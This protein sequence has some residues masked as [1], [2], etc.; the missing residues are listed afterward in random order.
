MQKHTRLNWIDYARGIAIILVVYRHLFE[1]LKRT[2]AL[3]AAGVNVESYLSLEHANIFFFSFRMPLFFIVSGVFVGASLAKRGFASLTENKARTILYPY[4]LW[5]II[6][7]G[8]QILF[9]A[10]INSKK[11]VYDFLYLLYSPREVEQFWYLYALFNTIIIFAFLKQNA[12]FKSI[13]QIILGFI[14]FMASALCS[15]YNIDL[16]FVSDIL[17]YYIFLALGDELSHL[18]IMGSL[19]KFFSSWKAF[20]IL[21]VPFVATQYYF[22]VTNIAHKQL[23]PKYLYV[24]YYQPLMYL[25][26]A[27]IGCAFIIT[28][29]SLLERYNAVNWL[30]VLGKHSLYIYVMHVIVFAATRV[31]LMRFF[32]IY[33]V[34]LLMVLCIASGVFVPVLFYRLT[35]KLGLWYLFTLEKPGL[36]NQKQEGSLKKPQPVYEN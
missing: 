22:L 5:G 28:V 27:L 4:F 1:G 34:Y 10:F 13:H 12:K 15:Q 32:H 2:P 29:S 7:I 16:Y 17:H 20:F 33:D 6:Q 8:I 25:V 36:P 18:I 31:V 26:V 23:S 35:G 24:E 14:F 9:S 11:S 21:I 3:K 19:R 30:R